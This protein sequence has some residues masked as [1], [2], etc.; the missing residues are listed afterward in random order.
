MT[1]ALTKLSY[2][3]QSSAKIVF[4]TQYDLGKNRMKLS[5]HYDEEFK[6]LKRRIF[7]AK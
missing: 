6:K 7:F 5:S 1:A 3:E 4:Y 2:S